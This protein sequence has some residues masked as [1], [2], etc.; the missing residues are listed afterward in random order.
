MM[1]TRTFD[2]ILIVGQGRSGTNWLL[3][4]LDI[5]PRTHCRNEPDKL[6]SS[7]LAKLP[8]P[9]TKQ[10]LG[11][12]FA[13]RWEQALTLTSLSMGER[14]RIGVHPKFHLYE[15]V[16]RLGGG[17]LISKSRLRQLFALIMPGW[18]QSEWIAPRWLA[19]PSALRQA[20]TVLKLNQVPGWAE[21][22]LLNQPEIL[23]IH[24]VRHPGGF[25]NSWQNRYLK[26]QEPEAVE[27]ANQER[28]RQVAQR[29]PQWAALFKDIG[30][31]S[32]E[33]SELWYWRY[34]AETIH[35]AGEG[36]SN[37]LRIIYEN[38]VADPLTVVRNLY[39]KCCLPWTEDIE[40]QVFQSS[41]G[42]NSIATAWSEKLQSEQVALVK[43]ILHGS[44]MQDWWGETS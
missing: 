27:Q 13:K 29:E 23:V 15:P 3:D 34:A 37:Y 32:V 8:S 33:E 4:L 17:Y 7:P 18:G 6:S 14:D 43:R 9:V 36:Q 40:K 22:V 2:D 5:S 30:D 16:R 39:E 11:E 31:M 44:S 20:A 12:D 41:S 38:L 1:H 19:N 21:W 28:L 24:I 26:T 35:A 10:P 25:L 42:S